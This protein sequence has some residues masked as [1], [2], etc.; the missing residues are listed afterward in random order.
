MQGGSA[1][2]DFCEDVRSLGRPDKRLGLLIVLGQVVLAGG[3]ELAHATKHSA[4]NPWVGEV[5]RNRS[6]SWGVCLGR[7]VPITLPSSVWSAAKSVVVR[8]RC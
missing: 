3:G 4:A 1:A 6:H 2:L 5:A 7:Q 8:L